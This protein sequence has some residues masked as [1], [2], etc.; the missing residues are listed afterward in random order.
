MIVRCILDK[1]K[2]FNIV[3]YGILVLSFS[4]LVSGDLVSIG[5]G[6]DEISL[7]YGNQIDLF[8]SGIT[9]TSITLPIVA[10]I[11]PINGISTYEADQ[12]YIYNISSTRDILYCSLIMDG[13]A[14]STDAGIEYLMGNGSCLTPAGSG[15]WA[16]TCSDNCVWS[17]DFSVSDNISITG[18]GILT[19]NANM[20]FINSHW[21]IYKEDGC[22]LVINPGGSIR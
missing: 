14:V 3:L 15:D 18:S 19:W 13:V 10:Q 9:T 16:I 1:M 4:I 21:E 11:S 8:F 20:S 22:E 5:T 12:L 2:S 7:G 17:T 6:G